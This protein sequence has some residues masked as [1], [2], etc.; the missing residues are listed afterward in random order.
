MYFNENSF[1]SHSLEIKNT[2]N[3]NF[4]IFQSLGW[5]RNSKNAYL[6]PIIRIFNEDFNPTKI[7]RFDS[8]SFSYVNKIKENSYSLLFNFNHDVFVYVTE[9][10]S[11]NTMISTSYSKDSRQQS[12]FNNAIQKLEVSAGISAKLTF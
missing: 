9:N 5:N 11:I 8:F 4:S 3:T 10:A 12:T 6:L 2:I 1:L 7:T